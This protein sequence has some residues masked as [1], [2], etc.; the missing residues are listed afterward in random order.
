M[1]SYG[2]LLK[3][4]KIAICTIGLIAVFCLLT[5]VVLLS[6]KIAILGYILMGVGSLL[7]VI[8]S[9]VWI[10]FELFNKKRR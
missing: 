7:F 5:G 10:I 8:M 6:F 3:S 4:Q 2:S 1:G 9:V